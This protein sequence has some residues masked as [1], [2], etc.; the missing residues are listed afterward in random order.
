[1]ITIAPIQSHQIAAA[2]M[3]ITAVAQRIFEPEKS[4]D[5]FATILDQEHELQDLD[6]VQQVYDGQ[7]AIFLVVLD[8]GRVVGTGAIKQYNKQTAE[9]K[10]MWLLEEYHGKGIGY[11]VVMRLFEFARQVGYKRICLQTSLQQKRAIA[12]Y[13]HIG[14]V[15]IP[16]YSEQ[17]YDDDISMG[18][19]L[20]E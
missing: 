15:E 5:E 12:F 14:F 13:K 1:M 17:L 7:K 9:L 6:Q 8:D 10:R 19:T 16:F 3:V 20:N 18:I 4:S 11:K 2:K